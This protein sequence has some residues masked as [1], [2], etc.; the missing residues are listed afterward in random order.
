MKGVFALKASESVKNYPSERRMYTNYAARA[1]KKVCKEIGPRF[2]GTEEEKK[3]IE[4]MAE[5]LKT[6]CD[7]VNIDAYKV[8]PKAFLGW[9]PLS[10]TLMTV[11]A[12]LFFIGHFGNIKLIRHRFASIGIIDRIL[13]AH[14]HIGNRKLTY[15]AVINIFHH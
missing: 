1:I 14:A 13:N 15:D 10:V 2:S 8:S 6:C 9:I 4:F 5:E 12:V 11:A 7:D 3:G